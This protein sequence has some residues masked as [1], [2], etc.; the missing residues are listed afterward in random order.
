MKTQE[1]QGGERGLRR[2]SPAGASSTRRPQVHV[3][4]ATQAVVIGCGSPGQEIPWTELSA[5]GYHSKD[6]AGTRVWT[7]LGAGGFG[8]DPERRGPAWD[9]A[10]EQCGTDTAPQL[11]PLPATNSPVP[12]PPLPGEDQ[13]WR[14][15]ELEKP[16][17]PGSAAIWLQGET[18]HL[19]AA[20][21]T[22]VQGHV[23]GQTGALT[24][25]RL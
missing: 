24:S 9:P 16:G 4:E 23:A 21:A 15:A 3:G 8:A 5:G 7:H 13:G 20:Y 11:E 18:E 6:K 10:L 19:V 1:R 12:S 17:A 25:P 14:T 22:H 2:P